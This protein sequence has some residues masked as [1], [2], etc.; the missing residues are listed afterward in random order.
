MI[1]YK[2]CGIYVIN[3]A[4]NGLFIGASAIAEKVA[5]HYVEK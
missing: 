4:G 2:L 1:S 5:Q 3:Q